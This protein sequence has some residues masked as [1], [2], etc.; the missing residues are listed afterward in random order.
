[1]ICKK[2]AIVFTATRL[3]TVL[4]DPRQVIEI[5]VEIV[6]HPG[7][8]LVEHDT[9][10]LLV[11]VVGLTFS[12]QQLRAR[13]VLTVAPKPTASS[14]SYTS[15]ERSAD[16]HETLIQLIVVV[17]SSQLTSDERQRPSAMR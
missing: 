16:P 15:L 6:E 10:L 7:K 14:R 5:A 12:P 8:F 2:N 1:M 11:V 13:D 3:L 17:A 4:T 9:V